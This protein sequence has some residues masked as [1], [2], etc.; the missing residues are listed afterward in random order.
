MSN[1]EAAENRRIDEVVG[2]YIR[3]LLLQVIAHPGQPLGIFRIVKAVEKKFYMYDTRE[4][5]LAV[6]RVT[7]PLPGRCS[8]WKEPHKDWIVF[9]PNACDE[10]ERRIDCIIDPNVGGL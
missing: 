2:D 7:S 9:N 8:R 3:R 10:C 6:V 4:A 1:A 5:Y